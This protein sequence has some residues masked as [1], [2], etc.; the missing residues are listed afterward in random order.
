MGCTFYPSTAH[1]HYYYQSHINHTLKHD[2]SRHIDKAVLQTE[3]FFNITAEDG[4]LIATIA[5]FPKIHLTRDSFADFR[6]QFIEVLNNPALINEPAKPIRVLA[7]RV[8][9]MIFDEIGVISSPLFHQTVGV[10]MRNGH[11]VGVKS[12]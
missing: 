3:H 1:N 7:V 12:P 6:F 4:S 10:E 8:V 11:C 2:F 5:L 9:E